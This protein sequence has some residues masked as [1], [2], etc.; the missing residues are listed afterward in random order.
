MYNPK[1]IDIHIRFACTGHQPAHSLVSPPVMVASGRSTSSMST[2]VLE[3]PVWGASN[4]K[5][6]PT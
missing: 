5:C 1:T 3:A 6:A 2:S 4:A